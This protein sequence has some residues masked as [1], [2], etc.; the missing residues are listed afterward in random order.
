MSKDIKDYLHF[1]LG[2]EVHSLGGGTAKYRLVGIDYDGSP[3]FRTITSGF[4]MVLT[5]WKLALRPIQSISK[6]EL[7]EWAIMG[8]I[9][10]QSIKEKHLEAA[11]KSIQN[12]G[13]DALLLDDGHPK[14][15]FQLFR[16]LLSKDFDVFELIPEGLV[17][18][19][20]K[21]LK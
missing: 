14:L 8:G 2:C 18:D 17:I 20:T 19:K 9:N 16:W 6:E 15:A 12:K 21:L 1:H 5:D 7:K 4:D 3:L 11:Q 13:L 10:E